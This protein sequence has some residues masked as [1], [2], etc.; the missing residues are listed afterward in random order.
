V[1][2]APSSAASWRR[3]AT[4][5]TATIVP[6]PEAKAAITADSPTPPAP[7]TTSDDSGGGASTFSTVPAPVC[8]PQPSGAATARSISSPTTTTFDS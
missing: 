7:N 5:S 1:A 2:V 3:L 8:T 4:G 6:T